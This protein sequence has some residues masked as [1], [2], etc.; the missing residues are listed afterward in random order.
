MA[1]MRENSSSA[2]GY[3]L[4]CAEN[5]AACTKTILKVQ[6]KVAKI[7]KTEN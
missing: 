2:I 7:N 3:A 4:L 1:G 6:Q 5:E